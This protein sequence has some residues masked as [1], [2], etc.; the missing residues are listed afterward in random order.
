MVYN[1][2]PTREWHD[3]DD[4]ASPTAATESIFLT[5]VINAKENRDAMTTDIPNTFIQARMPKVKDGEER[6]IMK[7]SG[8]LL[9]SLVRFAPDLYGKVV[10]FANGKR[11]LYFQVFR[12]LYGML[13]AALLWYRMFR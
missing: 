1:G 13:V 5:S 9:E 2:K 11:V 3:K 7:L 10:V 8:Q 12:A 4:T 6:V